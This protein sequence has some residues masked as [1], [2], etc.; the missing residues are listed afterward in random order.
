MND[1][2][3]KQIYEVVAGIVHEEHR[4]L[5][6]AIKE[7]RGNFLTTFHGFIKELDGRL[8]RLDKAIVAMPKDKEIDFDPVIA[9]IE[10]IPETDLSGLHDKLDALHER[11]GKIPGEVKLPEVIRLPAEFVRLETIDLPDKKPKHKA[12]PIEEDEPEEEATESEAEG[13]AENG[14]PYVPPIEPEDNAEAQEGP[15]EREQ[16]VLSA[17]RSMKDQGTHETTYSMI[18]KEVPGLQA[19][20]VLRTLKRLERKGMVIESEGHLWNLKD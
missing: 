4:D 19:I 3:I 2:D 1:K 18:A 8:S 17:L 11:V 20:Q 10:D 7:D 12:E 13:E 6:Q 9:A 15:D 14:M 16:S 5:E